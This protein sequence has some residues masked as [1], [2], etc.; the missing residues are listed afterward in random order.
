MT[1]EADWLRMREKW[2]PKPV[3]RVGNWGSKMVRTA[4]LLANEEEAAISPRNSRTG[5]AVLGAVSSALVALDIT[6]EEPTSTFEV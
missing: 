1:G 6:A 3:L 2:F 5:L 4:E